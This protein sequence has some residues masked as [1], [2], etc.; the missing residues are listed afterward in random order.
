VSTPL[1]I[2]AVD[3]ADWVH[4]NVT[5][6]QVAAIRRSKSSMGLYFVE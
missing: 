1:T 5:K 6:E 2:K 4:N 3:E